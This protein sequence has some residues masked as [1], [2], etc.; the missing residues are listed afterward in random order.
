VL[1]C[2]IGLAGKQPEHGAPVP[3]ASKARVEIET[4]VDQPYGDV[5]VLTVPCQHE[6]GWCEDLRVVRGGSERP[7][8]EIDG[9]TPGRLSVVRPAID[10]ELREEERGHGKGRTVTRIAVDCPSE[11]VEYQ[12]VPVTREGKLVRKSA[13]IEI[14]GREIAR[15]SRARSAELGC[16]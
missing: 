9:C 3:A 5:D 14:I 16:L 13:Q 10:V 7:S 1:D 4:T 15:R 12:G 8:S 2:K 6:G 11:Q